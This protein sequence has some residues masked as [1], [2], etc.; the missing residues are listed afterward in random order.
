MPVTSTALRSVRLALSYRES[1]LGAAVQF[2][3]NASE[4]GGEEEDDA[5]S[6]VWSPLLRPELLDRQWL[7]LRRAWSDLGLLP[8]HPADSPVEQMGSAAEHQALQK[9][10]ADLERL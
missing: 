4:D 7:R 10:L 6:I 2:A 9:V 8:D 3:E 5:S 1:G